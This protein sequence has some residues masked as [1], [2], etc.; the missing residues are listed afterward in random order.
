MYNLDL[1]NL[2]HRNADFVMKHGVKLGI[3]FYNEA[4]NLW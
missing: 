2:K 1:F 3:N 4:F